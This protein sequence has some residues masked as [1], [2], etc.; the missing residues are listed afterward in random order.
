MI[1]EDQ[2]KKVRQYPV[3]TVFGVISLILVIAILIRNPQVSSLRETNEQRER[4]WATIRTNHERS[5]DLEI[6][7]EKLRSFSEEVNRRLIS[8]DTIANNYDYFY[9]IERQTGVRIV[10]IQ[11]LPVAAARRPQYLPELNDYDLVP[12]NLTF[13]GGFDVTMT[14][15]QGI[16]RGFHLIRIESISINRDEGPGITASQ[17]TITTRIEMNILGRKAGR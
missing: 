12:F 1:L 5:A 17:R 15:L 11:Q 3:V 4:E 7:V 16:E 9:R 6:E 8:A 10:N 13:Q 2:I 14:F